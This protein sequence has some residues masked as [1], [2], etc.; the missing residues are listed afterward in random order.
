MELTNIIPIKY[1]S[2]VSRDVIDI[3]SPIKRSSLR[4]RFIKSSNSFFSLFDKE[5]LCR[6]NQTID[7]LRNDDIFKKK[8]YDAAAVSNSI[9]VLDYDA[10]VSRLSELNFFGFA[11]NY[12][13]LI[14]LLD[15]SAAFNISKKNFQYIQDFISDYSRFQQYFMD[16]AKVKGLLSYVSVLKSDQDHTKIVI[17]NYYQSIK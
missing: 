1:I 16:I 2:D 8:S 7:H 11:H 17:S 14:A 6:F 10:I 13:I 5:Y 3:P 15:T 9:P 4:S 12:Y